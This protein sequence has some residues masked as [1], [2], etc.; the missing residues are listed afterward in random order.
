MSQ[1][2]AENAKTLNRWSHQF[3]QHISDGCQ[4]RMGGGNNSGKLMPQRS[5]FICCTGRN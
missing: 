3:A 5:R 2:G 1:N 4:C